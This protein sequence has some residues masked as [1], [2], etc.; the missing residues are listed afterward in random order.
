MT[1]EQVESLTEQQI[2]QLHD[3]YRNE[4]WSQQRTPADIRRM[5]AQT[6]LIIG[7][8]EQATGELVGFCRLL[9][10]FTYHALLYDVI[11]RPDCRNQR[12][13]RRLME[14]VVNHPKL[15]S[16]GAVWLCCLPEMVPF[17][18]KYGFTG[19]IEPLQWMRCI[20]GKQD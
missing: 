3:L 5:L 20:P 4:W 11:V 17:Y 7:L 1:I 13:G 15:K 19:G 9:T 10:D 14:A 18:E 16:V 2:E 6:D 8:I 12:L